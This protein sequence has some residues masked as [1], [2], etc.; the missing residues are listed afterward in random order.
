M[1]TRAQLG[2]G[3]AGAVVVAALLATGLGWWNAGQ[4]RPALAHPLGVRTRLVPGAAF[5]GDP[6]VA[7]V[8]V[9]LDSSVVA[10]GSVRVE[11]S[12]APYLESGPPLVERS[13][14]GRQET[15]VYSYTLQ[16]V[17][18]GCLPVGARR[19]VRLPAVVVTARAG[20]RQLTVT[21]ALPAASVA[22]RLGPSSLASAAPQF[23]HAS[24]LPPPSYAVT[25]TVLA[26]TLTVVAGL[27]G[28]G[29]AALLGLELAALARRRR[30]ALEQ[31]TLLV[32]AL[33]F[34]RDAAGRPDAADRRKA[35]E[36]LA[37]ALAGQ[38]SPT[39]AD[40][41]ERV[42]WAEPPPSAQRTLELADQVETP[43]EVEPS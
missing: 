8:A 26:L 3:L 43:G 39:L 37:E 16:C 23:L 38:G 21:A 9:D 20:G 32:S 35:L 42:A 29:A 14:V 22:S 19:V 12:F 15:I 11:P 6:V 31:P 36:L 4:P 10:P 13:T 30:A 27:L 7:Q 28:A 17:S 1:T 18:D 40:T 24:A 2:T 33:A 5:F 25:P 34:V 41:A